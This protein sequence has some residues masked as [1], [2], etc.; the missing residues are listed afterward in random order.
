MKNIASQINCQ[1]KNGIRDDV[2]KGVS[3]NISVELVIKFWNTFVHRFIRVIK[4]NTQNGKY[5]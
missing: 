2:Y 4:E 1:V 5:K 3:D